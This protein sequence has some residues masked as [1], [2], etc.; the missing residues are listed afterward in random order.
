MTDVE[1]DSD[2]TTDMLQGV[3]D[4]CVYIH[5]SVED[6][7]KQFL[8]ELRRHNYV[9]PTSYLELLGT[10][11]KVLGEKK[12]ELGTVKTRLSVGLDKLNNTTT[13]VEK[14]KEDLRNLQPVLSRRRRR[15]MI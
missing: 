15:L 1:L 4:S 2:G 14:M 10:F 9:T 5:Q 11:L 3:V 12:N 8:E 13:E 6:K 7:S